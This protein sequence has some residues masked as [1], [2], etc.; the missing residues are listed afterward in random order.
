MTSFY[1]KLSHAHAASLFWYV[2]TVTSQKAENT[3]VLFMEYTYINKG[4]LVWESILNVG[5]HRGEG[6]CRC[7]G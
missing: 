6:L 4:Y 7:E 2:L 3:T 1:L 5:M